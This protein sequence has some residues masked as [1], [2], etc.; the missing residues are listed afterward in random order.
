MGFVSEKGI[1]Y[2]YFVLGVGVFWLGLGVV[3]L[4]ECWCWCVLF[5]GKNV[6]EEIWS[7]F[8]L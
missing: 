4:V 7:G 3:F 8:V 5:D 2:F 6:C 1:F